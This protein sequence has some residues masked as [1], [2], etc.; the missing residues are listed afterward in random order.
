VVVRPRKGSAAGCSRCHLP[1]PSYD[2]LAVFADS[3]LVL[4]KA[5]VQYLYN[6]PRK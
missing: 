3:T 2:Q 4:S 1:A 6:V 5:L